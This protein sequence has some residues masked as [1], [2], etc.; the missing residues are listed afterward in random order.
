[1]ISFFHLEAGTNTFY[2]F[3][4]ASEVAYEFDSLSLSLSLSLHWHDKGQFLIISE[5]VAEN[6]KQ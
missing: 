5:I 4:C 6:A 2:L 3:I 1:L